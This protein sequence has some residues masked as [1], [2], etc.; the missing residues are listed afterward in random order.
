MEGAGCRGLVSRLEAAYLYCV[1]G[2]VVEGEAVPLGAEVV[3]VGFGEQ[4]QLVA[5]LQQH[6]QTVAAAQ[7]THTH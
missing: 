5:L 4:T 7:H 6:V 1:Y 2:M 3:C